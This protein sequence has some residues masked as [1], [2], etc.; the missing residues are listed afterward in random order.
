MKFHFSWSHLSARASRKKRIP[1]QFLAV[2]LG[3]LSFG[4]GS[5]DAEGLSPPN[6]THPP[7]V[8]GDTESSSARQ[9]VSKRLAVDMSAVS[10]EELVTDATT[11][12]RLG[13][14]EIAAKLGQL[15]FQI[16]QHFSRLESLQA[17]TL[18]SDGRRID[19]PAENILA[20]ELPNAPQLRTF[21]ADVRSRTIVFPDAGGGDTVHYRARVRERSPVPGGLSDFSVVRPD[22]YIDRYSISF[23]SNT[24]VP[25]REAS[26]GF[27]KS[28]TEFGDRRLTTW[29][30][31]PVR[32]AAEEPGA[33]APID[34]DPYVLISTY[35]DWRTIGAAAAAGFALKGEPTPEVRALADRLT[36]GLSDPRE[37]ATVIRDWVAKNVRYFY[38]MLGEGGYVPHQPSWVLANRFGDCKDHVALA[39]ALLAAKGIDSIPVLI[40][41]GASYQLPTVPSQRWFNHAILWLPSLKQFTDPTANHSSFAALPEQEADKPVL[42][43]DGVTN[44][45]IR[46]PALDPN[47]NRL[48]YVSN[49]TLS[50]DGTV[51][52]SST[53]SASGQLAEQLREARAA[54]EVDGGAN[55]AGKVLDK[56]HWHGAGT[57]SGPSSTTYSDPYIIST[58]YDLENNFFGEANGNGN[59]LPIGPVL[60]KPAA[61]DFFNYMRNHHTQDFVCRAETHEETID[62]RLPETRKLIGLPR[63]ASIDLPLVR[64]A[65]HY[66]MR[67]RTLHVE[68]IFVSR[69][70]HQTC[71][72]AMVAE[73]KPVLDLA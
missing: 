46:L 10:N 67:G 22:S 58:T 64:Y 30:L 34:R 44:A 6:R 69:V 52:G 26:R 59:P 54:G 68:R 20:S 35:P 27:I 29:T 40:G 66:T 53:I 41:T 45:V 9:P 61:F 38:V 25:L 5:A 28:V 42:I 33:T 39:R 57:I 51:H 17:A 43:A 56:Y 65:V 32:H 36:A 63:N 8:P 21:L 11:D 24:A 31:G 4:A 70:P 2:S 7:P 19:A 73:M 50:Q 47:T 62:L 15:S 16:N 13:S 23:E 1:A 3:L 55:Y 49:A 71:T 18:K 72:A 37:Q 14:D 48:S 12:I 60:V